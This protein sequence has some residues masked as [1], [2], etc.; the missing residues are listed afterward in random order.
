[1]DNVVLARILD[2]VADLLEVQGANAFR[3]RAY[4]TAARTI[5]ALGE[6]AASIV[7]RE[8]RALAELPGIGAD[9]ARKIA[10][11]VHTGDLALRRELARE[12][13]EGVVEMMRIQDVGPKR[14]K[15]FWDELGIHSVGALAE[16]A[17]AG[18]LLDVRGI[19]AVLQRRILE[20]CERQGTAPTKRRLLLEADAAARDLLSWLTADPAVTRA[21]VAGSIR[22]RKETVGDVDLLAAS[23][24]PRAVAERFVAYPDVARVVA[25]GETRC[26]V[27]LRSGLQVDLRIVSADTYG[28]AL[29]YF[30]GS[31]AHNIAIRTMALER[32]L[33]V[34]EYGVFRGR[35]RVGG[36]EERDVYDAVQLPFI[37]PELREDHG[38]IEAARSARLPRLV[39]LSD[40]RGD[41]HV[42]TA[43]TDDGTDSLEVMVDAAAARGYAYVAITDPARAVRTASG[44]DRAGLRAQGRA[45]DALRR[46]RGITI[47][48]GAEVD[49]LEDGG[50]D[51]DDD[52]LDG[53]E[54]VVAAVHAKLDMDERPMTERVLRALHHPRVAILAHPTGRLL[55]SRPPSRLDLV[56]I[57]RAARELGV[58]LEINAQPERL[59]LCDVLVRMAMDEGARFVV[60][61]DAHRAAELD[62]MRYGIDQARRGW[63]TASDVANTR[64]LSELVRMHPR[65]RPARVEPATRAGGRSRT[66]SRRRPSTSPP[67]TPR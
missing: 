62:W 2:G 67:R 47:L 38:E 34:S 63:C 18:R 57:V 27:A 32:G 42:H 6:P 65:I 3:V 21:S 8:P 53:L 33:K 40:V 28:A 36:A 5:E 43:A 59:D 10:E 1:M 17:R 4:R 66:R 54:V 14:A 61:T 64:S 25:R 24:N 56:Q 49:V 16:A 37:E 55:G 7:A 12:I 39:A 35:R 30:T 45:I 48:R 50:L 31:K 11:I 44:L 15:L 41:L 13:P 19:G 22:R 58:L 29:A 20:G 51:L 52:A 23:S 9:L 60:D 46:R 26:A